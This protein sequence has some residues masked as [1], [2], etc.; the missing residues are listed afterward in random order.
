MAATTLIRVDIA[1]ETATA[2]TISMEV[3]VCRE[4]TSTAPMEFLV[5]TTM[6]DT[7]PALVGSKVGIKA[8]GSTPFGGAYGAGG[9]PP[10]GAYG[11][12]TGFSLWIGR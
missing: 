8:F 11:A 6:A 7:G 12:G 9:F 1:E 4:A 3:M 5:Q 10:G 2:I